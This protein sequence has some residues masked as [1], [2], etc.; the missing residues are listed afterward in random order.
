M[1][2]SIRNKRKRYLFLFSGI[3]LFIALLVSSVLAESPLLLYLASAVPM[4]IV[5]FLPDI[6]KNQQLQPDR[7]GVEIVKLAAAGDEPEWLVVSFAPGT[8]QWDKKVLLVPVKE[9]PIVTQL[10]QADYTASLTVLAYDLHKR[11]SKR[12]QIG[13]YLPNLIERTAGLPYTIQEVN[14]LMIRMEDIENLLTP[15]SVSSVRQ[16]RGVELQA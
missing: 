16:S 14:R 2:N 7:Q 8:V 4:F 13:I 12:G 5:P 15:K 1:N 3:L 10:P 11:K 6:P 9:A